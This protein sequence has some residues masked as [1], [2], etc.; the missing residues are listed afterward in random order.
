MLVVVDH[1]N[2]TT[3][4]ALCNAHTSNNP[5]V[6][7]KTRSANCGWCDVKQLQQLLHA[8]LFLQLRIALHGINDVLI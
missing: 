8:P 1:R 5:P 6:S 2:S 3:E 7:R 4:T